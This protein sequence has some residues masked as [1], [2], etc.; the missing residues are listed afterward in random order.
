M[1]LNIS[2]KQ[3]LKLNLPSPTCN[4]RW[5]LN[6]EADVDWKTLKQMELCM[7]DQPEIYW[8]ATVYNTNDHTVKYIN[9]LIPQ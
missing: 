7:L 6:K 9:V 8:K 1:E 5:R 4:V 3:E 2:I